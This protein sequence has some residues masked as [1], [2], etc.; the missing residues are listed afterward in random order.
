MTI[1]LKRFSYDFF[2]IIEKTC[3]ISYFLKLQKISKLFTLVNTTKLLFDDQHLHL[4]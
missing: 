4:F 2:F 3:N 1:I